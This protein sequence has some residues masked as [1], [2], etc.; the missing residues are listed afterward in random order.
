MSTLLSI[1]RCIRTERTESLHYIVYTSV[2]YM[3]GRLRGLTPGGTRPLHCIPSEQ[4]PS[5][6]PSSVPA[7]RLP[8]YSSFIGQPPTSPGF[9]WEEWALFKV[10]AKLG[11][12]SAETIAVAPSQRILDKPQHEARKQGNHR[13]GERGG[14]GRP[15]KGTPTKKTKTH[16]GGYPFF[17]CV[18]FG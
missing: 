1:Q 3:L 12:R 16:Q 11:R 10:L 15:C 17:L 6:V 18:Y 13:S 14:G 4:G 5:I 2:V 7:Q 8:A 9:E